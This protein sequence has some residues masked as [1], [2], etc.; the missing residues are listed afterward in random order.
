MISKFKCLGILLCFGPLF[1]D[2]DLLYFLWFLSL[3]VIAPLVGRAYLLPCRFLFFLSF[4]S[5]SLTYIALNRFPYLTLV[6]TD[7]LEDTE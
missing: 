5:L 7:L 1:K 2:T 3:V 4:L 6:M